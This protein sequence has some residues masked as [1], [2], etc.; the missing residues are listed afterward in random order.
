M[1]VCGLR[2]AAVQGCRGWTFP[3]R[4]G[5]GA[6]PAGQGLPTPAWRRGCGRAGDCGVGSAASDLERQQAHLRQVVHPGG[7]QGSRQLRPDRT[8]HLPGN[9][10]PDA[11]QFLPAEVR[12]PPVRPCADPGDGMDVWLMDAV[13]PDAL[14]HGGHPSEGLSQAGLNGELGHHAARRLSPVRRYL[15]A[16]AHQPRLRTPSRAPF[17]RGIYRHPHQRGTAGGRQPGC[18]LGSSRCPEPRRRRRRLKRVRGH[19]KE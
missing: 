7:D 14:M 5:P 11:A 6:G 15:H 9:C 2:L 19:Q 1:R 16:T 13:F 17:R 8:K 10:T 4:P 3:A 18:A 12:S